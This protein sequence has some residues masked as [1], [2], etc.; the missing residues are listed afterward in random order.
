LASIEYVS[1]LLAL[2]SKNEDI[3]VRRS[4]RILASN[5]IPEAY[6]EQAIAERMNSVLDSLPSLFARNPRNSRAREVVQV[7]TL[8]TRA[9]SKA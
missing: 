6:V 7:L 9:K 1:A 8:V 3:L 2:L 4:E 5:Q